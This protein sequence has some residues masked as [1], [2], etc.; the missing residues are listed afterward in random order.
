MTGKP[1][2]HHEK[3]DMKDV[4]KYRINRF[5]RDCAMKRNKN[6]ENDAETVQDIVPAERAV[7]KDVDGE[8][9]ASE[10]NPCHKENGDNV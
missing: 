7:T 3:T 2:G 8:K 5:C 9:N 4:A 10:Q 6:A 1:N